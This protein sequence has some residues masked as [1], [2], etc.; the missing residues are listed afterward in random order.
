MAHREYV[1]WQV[2][3]GREAQRMELAQK[4]AARGR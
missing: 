2:Y 1:G 3:F 4:A